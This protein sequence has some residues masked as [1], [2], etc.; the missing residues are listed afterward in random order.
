MTITFEKKKISIETNYMF[1]IDLTKRGT[2]YTLID[3]M[4]GE[5]AMIHVNNSN[6]ICFWSG[7]PAARA[8]IFE[9][10]PKLKKLQINLI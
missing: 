6:Q 3:N 8:I 10:F 2:Y 1:S 7:K 5:E 9:H 4:G